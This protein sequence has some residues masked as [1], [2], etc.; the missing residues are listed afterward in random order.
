MV[1][2]GQNLMTHLWIIKAGATF[3]GMAGEYGDFDQW[4][5]DA[6]G[7]N[8]GTVRVFDVHGVLPLPDPT[9]CDGVVITGSHA[10]VT[11]GLPWSL[12]LEEWIPRLV[13][14]K[15]PLLGIC[16]GHQLLARALG[17]EVDFH[18]E[19][20]E[21]GTVDIELLPECLTD[22]LFRGM[23]GTIPAHVVHAQTVKSLPEGAVRLAAN[24]FEPNHA[25][26][27]G[28]STWGLQFHPE[29]TAHIMRSY[30]NELGEELRASG[31]SPFQLQNAVRETPAARRVLERFG[32][33][34]DDKRSLPVSYDSI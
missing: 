30:I 26:R 13:G 1:N 8:P 27:I 32:R 24:D 23:S 28:S 20:R 12:A 21:I 15:V 16:Y 17:G 2:L 5:C 7:V 25:F 18:P 11:E 34:V 4:T 31:R 10:M 6:L 22:P 29:Y 33:I 9:A 19:G 14:A 3:P